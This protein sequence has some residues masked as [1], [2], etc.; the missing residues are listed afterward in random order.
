LATAW[1]LVRLKFATSIWSARRSHVHEQ[2]P[3]LTVVGVC[4]LQPQHEALLWVVQLRVLIQRLGNRLR[5]SQVWV[6]VHEPGCTPLHQRPLVVLGALRNGLLRAVLGLPEDDLGL[7]V[8][9]LADET[10]LVNSMSL[11]LLG[12]IA[13][14]GSG[15]QG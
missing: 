7:R 3:P 12:I 9:A 10:N 1:A 6:L 13:S 11:T 5:S 4:L 15:P 14:Q 8:G 2:V